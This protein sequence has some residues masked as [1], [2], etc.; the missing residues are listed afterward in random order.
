MRLPRK[1]VVDKQGQ[2]A[3]ESK[4]RWYKKNKTLQLVRQKKEKK[5]L[6]KWFEDYKR[7]L[8]FSN[9]ECNLSFEKHPCL[10]DF[11]HI[12]PNEKE[13]PVGRLVYYGKKRLLKEIEKCI[14]LCA[15]CHR[16][17]HADMV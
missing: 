2:K 12:D 15:H 11:H 8:R 10:C 17:L 4:A 6:A 1:V 5:E 13:S 14:P 7:T 9:I 16:I 3:K